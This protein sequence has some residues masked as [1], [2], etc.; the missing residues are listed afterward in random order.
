[1][2]K[3]KFNAFYAQSGGVTSVINASACGVIETARLYSDKI[4][5]V[6]AGHNGICG[7]LNEQL[8]DTS[9][10]SSDEISKLR[11]T[12]GGAFGSCRLKLA[13]LEDDLSQYERIVDVFR[14]HNIRYFFYNGGGDSQNTTYK[15]SKYC[16]QVGYPLKCIGIPKTIDNDLPYTDFSPGFPSTAKYIAISIKEAGLDIASMAASSTQIFV[17]EVMGRH[18]G[19]IAAAASLAS[20]SDSMAPHLILFPEVEFDVQ[21]FLEK[22]DAC[23]KKHGYCTIVAAEGVKD[24]KG[25]FISE[26]GG[27]I[28]AFG[29][30][31]LGGVSEKICH[32]IKR[33]LG[34]KYHRALADYLQRSARHI[35]SKVDVDCAY[36]LGKQAVDLALQG[37]SD[38]MLTLNRSKNRSK[39]NLDNINN[40]NNINWSVGQ[41]C[42]SKVAAVEKPM[43]L[44][45][46]DSSGYGVSEQCRNYL[47]PLI[48]GEDYPPYIAGLPD[49][50][51][52]E[53]KL[54]EQVLKASYCI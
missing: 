35:S 6:F 2:S 30:H 51:N 26:Q 27:E 16:Q 54:V 3:D 39:N 46:I 53:L 38:V 21:D 17:L 25:N 44:N 50:A 49:Y 4:G 52:L 8:I 37:V 18:A 11:H 13:E 10:Y 22:V 29:H 36:M 12:P 14:A 5:T 47:L 1:M 24:K 40:I 31:Q 42:L 33:N 48:Q 9:I 23:V 19:W 45:Y 41:V 7:A 28:D 34:Y 15:L 32:L 20:E 43:P